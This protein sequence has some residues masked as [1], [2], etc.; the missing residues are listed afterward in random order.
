MDRREL[1]LLRLKANIDAVAAAN[2][3]TFHA[4]RDRA[5]FNEGDLP[6]YV[7]LDGIESNS[8]T[9][10]DQGGR[11]GPCV[12]LMLPQIFFVPLPTENKL[13]VGV[14]ENLSV[15]RARLLKKIMMDSQLA[16]LLGS[17]GYIEYRG[18]E[19]DMQTGAEVMGQFRLEFALAYTL[20]FTKL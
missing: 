14:G 2:G 18:M 12:M 8:I 10:A 16:D 13:N 4:W 3:G 19:T 9:V 17:N 20:D 11:R 15:H 7:L 1:I 6:A 5:E